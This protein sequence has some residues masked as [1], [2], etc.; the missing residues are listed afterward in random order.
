[1]SWVDPRPPAPRRPATA[2]ER[3]RI[4]VLLL[5]PFALFLAA[6]AARVSYLRA[7]VPELLWPTKQRKERKKGWGRSKFKQGSNR[8][9]QDGKGGRS[10]NS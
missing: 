7:H 8:L 4:L 10:A 2:A 6:L 3:R 9:S 1:M 5:S